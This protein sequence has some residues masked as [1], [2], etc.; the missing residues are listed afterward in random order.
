LECAESPNRVSS[1]FIVE[2]V[3]NP[4]WRELGLINN[5]ALKGEVL[6]P[7]GTNETGSACKLLLTVAD[8]LWVRQKRK[9]LNNLNLFQ[10]ADFGT[11]SNNITLLVIYNSCKQIGRKK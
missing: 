9:F 8:R 6:N 2:A 1:G 11:S 10:K 7:I 5:L 3:S 4:G